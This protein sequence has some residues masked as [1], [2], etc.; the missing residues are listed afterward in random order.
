VHEVLAKSLLD[1]M[2]AHISPKGFLGVC[3]ET[4]SLLMG[5]GVHVFLGYVMNPTPWHDLHSL[6]VV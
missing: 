4:D 1:R 5:G 2:I 6:S 3:D